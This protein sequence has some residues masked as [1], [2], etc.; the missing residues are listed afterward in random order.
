[1]NSVRD[2]LLTAKLLY[3]REREQLHKFIDNLSRTDIDAI[4]ACCITLVPSSCVE[5]VN[6][7]VGDGALPARIVEESGERLADAHI[8]KTSI[9]ELIRSPQPSDPALDHWL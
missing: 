9:H 7:L 6:N 5:D 3:C 2:Q 1:M 4:L 8:P